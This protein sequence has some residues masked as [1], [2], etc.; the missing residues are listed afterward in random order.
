VS[1]DTYVV[2]GPMLFP[3][4]VVEHSRAVSSASCSSSLTFARAPPGSH[5]AV[6]SATTS[7][8]AR[9]RGDPLSARGKGSGSSGSSSSSSSSSIA[10]TR[11]GSF[12]L[13]RSFF[14]LGR[15]DIADWLLSLSLSLSPPSPYGPSVFLKR[16]PLPPRLALPSLSRASA[17]SLSLSPSL[18][19]FG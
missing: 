17:R 13:R 14:L 11:L 4:A 18:S 3:R 16:P 6:D 15:L 7:G 12:W 19:V 8:K 2:R 5:S 10:G 9:G 1:G